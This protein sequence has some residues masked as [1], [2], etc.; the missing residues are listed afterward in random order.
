MGCLKLTYD[1]EEQPLFLSESGE[2]NYTLKWQVWTNPESDFLEVG[3]V[4]QTGGGPIDLG[5]ASFRDIMNG[6]KSAR[7]NQGNVNYQDIFGFPEALPRDQ[8]GVGDFHR[9]KF[10]KGKVEIVFTI[11]SRDRLIDSVDPFYKG[12]PAGKQR[13]W[14]INPD[15][16]NTVG[17]FNRPIDYPYSIGIFAGGLGSKSN[18]RLAT[19]FFSDLNQFKEWKSYIGGK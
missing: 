1:Y 14:G 9:K 18:E 16:V 7:N 5:S 4:V 2:K 17:L 12:E 13:G 11:Q 15:A 8:S 3:E 19:V 6:F 10:F